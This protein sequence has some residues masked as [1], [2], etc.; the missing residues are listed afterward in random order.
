MTTPTT[1]STTD[2]QMHNNIMAASS[3]D[4]PPMLATGRYAQWQSHFLRYID[5]R[6]NGDALRK[7]IL[8]EWFRFDF[9]QHQNEVNE[10][11]AEKI[12]KNAILLALVAAAQQYPNT[13]YQ[14]QKSHESYTPP[15]KKSSSTR[16]HATTIYKCK[17]IA[18]PITPPPSSEEDSDPEQAQRDKYM[19]KNLALIAKYF[20]KIYKP[21]NNN[22]K[23]FSNTRNK[24]VNTSPRYKNENQ[25][26]QFRNQRTVTVVEAR[27]TI[28]SQQTA[29]A[30]TLDTR[31]IQI[32]STIH[33]NVK[34]IYEESIRRHLKLEDSDGISTLSNTEIFEQL[35]LMGASKGYTGVDILLFLTML[36]Q[37][38]QGEGSTAPVESIK[39][40]QEIQQSHNPDIHH[41]LGRMIEDIDQDAGVILVTLTKVSS[42][43]DQPKDQL[44]VLSAAKIFVDATRVHTYSKRRR[45]ISTGRDRVSTASRIIS[46]AEETISTTSVSMA[47]ST[48]GIVQ[49]STSSPRAT[50]DK[51]KAIMIESKPEQTTTKLRERQE[52]VGYEATI[53]SV[54]EQPVEEEKELLQEDL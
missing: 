33:G 11:H 39:H 50:R 48:A 21:T 54:Q 5:T 49:E 14:A 31:E 44:G 7:C 13:Y 28:G 52:R 22:L 38:L 18:K 36:V 26:G 4:H 23:T 47:V 6:P 35:A 16:S 2:S 19:Q 37:G 3:R 27:E 46:T 24:N 42:Q 29:V 45:A 40:P 30:N 17:E 25:T 32:T 12:A 34:L 15:S 53:R 20:K 1:T 41:L 43:E 10:I 8:H 51:G 9:C